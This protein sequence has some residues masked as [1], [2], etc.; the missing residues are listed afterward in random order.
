MVFT[1]EARFTVNLRECTSES[2]AARPESIRSRSYAIWADWVRLKHIQTLSDTKCCLYYSNQY[3]HL[4]TTQP[5]IIKFWTCLDPSAITWIRAS[6]VRWYWYAISPCISS[7]FFPTNQWMGRKP[8]TEGGEVLHLFQFWHKLTCGSI[9]SSV[10]QKPAGS[11][12]CSASFKSILFSFWDRF[13]S[14]PG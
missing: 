10:K 6:V 14:S 12:S 8:R 2:A 1:T 4:L 11:V 13:S 9:F 3:T 5:I 7:S